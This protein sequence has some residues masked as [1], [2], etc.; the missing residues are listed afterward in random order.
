[1]ILPLGTQLPLR[2]ATNS[3]YICIRN[4]SVAPRKSFVSIKSPLSKFYFG[5]SPNLKYATALI[6]SAFTIANIHPSILATLGPP[7]GVLSFF[8]YRRAIQ[9]QYNKNVEVIRPKSYGDLTSDTIE[10]NK[11][12][13]TDVN[14]VLN[15]IESEFDSFQDQILKKVD[16]RIKSSIT[17]E[18]IFIDANGQVNYKLG[19]IENFVLLKLPVE[20]EEF[21]GLLEF[22]K[23]GVVLQGESGLLKESRLAIA[24]VYLVKVPEEEDDKTIKYKMKVFVYPYPKVERQ[25]F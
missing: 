8:I 1:M 17:E 3:R 16:E 6:T 10:I 12:D 4:V 11:Y 19:D 21:K 24:E 15:G 18:S 22:V 14:N 5:I 2:A 9:W 23:F 7:V 20:F 25:A 13:E